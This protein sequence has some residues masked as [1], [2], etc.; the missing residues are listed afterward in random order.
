MRF[1]SPSVSLFGHT[2]ESLGICRIQMDI[3]L[4][5][6]NRDPGFAEGLI[7]GCVQLGDGYQAIVQIGQV[8]AQQKVQRAVTESFECRDRRR[9]L[10]EDRMVSSFA[11]HVDL[12]RPLPADMTLVAL[13]RL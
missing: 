3:S 1:G 5:E 4:R 2:P 12:S 11:G 6:G 10:V 8:A 9:I 13:P 7:N